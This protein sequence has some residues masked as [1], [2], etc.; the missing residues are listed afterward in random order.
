[1]FLPPKGLLYITGMYDRLKLIIS[2]CIVFLVCGLQAQE[3]DL[4]YAQESDEIPKWVK[5]MYSSQADPGQVTRAYEAYYKQHEF[6]KNGHTQYYKRW[7]RTMLRDING[8]NSGKVDEQAVLKNELLYKQ[9]ALDLKLK[10]GSTNAWS[11]LGPIDFDKEAAGRSYA[12]GAAHVYTVEQ[13]RSNPDVLYAGTA[14]TGLWKSID[15]GEHWELMTKD[16]LVNGIRS[17]EIDHTN[18][19]VVYFNHAGGQVYKSIDGGASWVM[20]E[21][22]VISSDSHNANDIVMCP[23]NSNKLFLSSQRGLFRTTDGG[24]SWIQILEGA[25]QEIEFHP[26]DHNII[27]LVKQTGNRTEFYKST[28][29]GDSFQLKSNG[30]PGILNSTSSDEFNYLELNNA[31]VEMKSDVSLGMGRYEDFTIELRVRVNDIEGDPA[32]VSN[33]NWDNGSFKGFVI[34]ALDDGTWKFNIGTGSSRIDLDG[35][36]IQDGAWHHLAISY[37]QDGVK[38]IYQDGVLLNEVEDLLLGTT[39]NGN[40]NLVIGQ[41]GRTTYPY[42]YNGGIA[43]LRIWDRA[44]S[45]SSIAAYACQSLNS[46][47]PEMNALEHHWLFNE[48]NGGLINNASGTI[49]GI[50]EGDAD[51]NTGGQ[52]ICVRSDLEAGEEQKRTEIAVTEANPSKI[53]ALATGNAN[54]GSGLFGIYISEDEGE[55]WRFQ[56]CG[57]Q[58]GGPAAA[59][60]NIN[61]MGWADDG[62]DDGGQ[63]YYDL[64]LDVSP[65]DENKIFV[66]GVNLWISDDG[67]ENFVCPAKWSHS[68]KVNYVHADIH[69]VRYIGNEIWV[70]CD[71]GIFFSDDNASTF[72][73]KMKGIAG[74]DFWGFGASFHDP[75]VMLGGTYHNGTLLK[76]NDVY[77]NGWIS[78]RGGDNF[79]GFVNYGDSRIVYDDGGKRRLPGDRTVDFIGLPYG[80]KPNASFVTGESSNIAYD[81]RSY[82]ISWTGYETG[83]WKTYDD[84]T[85]WDLLYDFGEKVTRVEVARTDP[86]V[87]YACTFIDWWGEKKV[88]RSVDGGFTWTNITPTGI[89]EGGLWPPLDVAVCSKDPMKIWLARV[90]QSGGYNPLDGNKV[91]KSTD[92]GAQWENVS[93]PTLDGEHLTNLCY[94]RGTNGGIYL[95]TRRAVYYKNDEMNDWELYN[96]DLPLSTFSTKLVPFYPGGKIRNGTNRSVHECAFFEPSMPE[97]QISAERLTSY[98]TR[99]EIQFIDHSVLKLDGASWEWHFPGGIPEYSTEQHPKVTYP[100]PGSFGVSLT[101]TNVDGS[102]SQTLEDF[103]L[104][105]SDCDPERIPGTAMDLS[106][107]G[108]YLTSTELNSMGNGVDFTASCWVK[109]N[110]TQ[111]EY[112]GIIMGDENGAFGLNFRPNMELGYH[113]AGGQWYWSSGLTVPSDEWSHVALV[114][115]ADGITLYLNGVG[116]KH[117]VNPASKSFDEAVYY[118]GSYLAWG[119]RNYNGLMDEVCIWNRALTE[120]EIRESMHLTKNADDES[121]RLYY[122]FNAGGNEVSDRIG[123]AHP[124][125]NGETNKTVSNAPVGGGRAETASLLREGVYSFFNREARLTLND[126]P[127]GELVISQIEVD[128][129]EYPN[130]FADEGYWVIHHFG[131]E[132]IDVIDELLLSSPEVLKTEEYFPQGF[133]LY[134]RSFNAEQASWEQHSEAVQVW[135]GEKGSAQF[136]NVATSQGQFSICRENILRNE[137][138]IAIGS[139]EEQSPSFRVFP[140]PCSRTEKLNIK[141]KDIGV[142]SFDIYNV[143]G[144]KMQSFHIEESEQVSLED[145]MPGIYFYQVIGNDKMINGSFVIE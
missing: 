96:N 17:I 70:A 106:A 75:E 134:N 139:L 124:F 21:D 142:F 2:I 122:Q 28:D 40:F 63:Y 67:G 126:A 29:G 125:N 65:T 56:C 19:N 95:G 61:M 20:L 94:Q 129:D 38:R 133:K 108:A 87:L 115:E 59:E 8:L 37:D 66:A 80:K 36:Y 4:K 110:G 97:A 35:G 118:F 55:S 84:G 26:T 102:D 86:N 113:W 127:T 83:I 119:G 44:L 93:T 42:F 112:T 136:L 10:N 16:L 138:L 52:S 103:I 101:I 11:C 128:P 47:H 49:N 114:A 143:E 137:D 71:G 41:D 68:G 24:A 141:S 23:H 13:S 62:S 54:G 132:K 5:M 30:W 76:D 99:N 74:T 31:Y 77:E 60:S 105:T 107:E 131:N 45:E 140:N 18:P 1:M 32:I 53:Y 22:E 3:L 98:C 104:V 43:D 135:S 72:Q 39:S 14:T 111:N 81:P 64:G 120:Q 116:V 46:A 82:N 50:I 145:L 25:Y 33:K 92:G 90:P 57:L 51:W 91:F 121:L 7:I 15:H 9:K 79:R 73:R 109:P 144:K 58:P 117:E 85:S 88:Y 27:Y 48:S 100:S 6:T 78:T 123:F 130:R 89:F 12:A 34:A 69:D